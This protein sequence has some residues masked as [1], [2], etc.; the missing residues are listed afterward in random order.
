MSQFAPIVAGKAPRPRKATAKKVVRFALAHEESSY[1]DYIAREAA[2]AHKIAQEEAHNIQLLRQHREHLLRWGARA[3]EFESRGWKTPRELSLEAAR[4]AARLEAALEAARE[5]A[6]EDAR[7]FWRE[8]F[9]RALAGSVAEAA[10]DKQL[11]EQQ[12]LRRKA[13]PREGSREGS[14]RWKS[15]PEAATVRKPK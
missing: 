5:D 14:R 9:A 1:V 3:A 7:T 2:R 8:R 12:Y 13:R 11:I 15:P 4:E 10:H 6:R